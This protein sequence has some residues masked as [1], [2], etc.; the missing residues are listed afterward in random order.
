MHYVLNILNAVMHS[1]TCYIIACK[2]VLNLHIITADDYV[3]L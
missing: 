1:V 2:L 3:D